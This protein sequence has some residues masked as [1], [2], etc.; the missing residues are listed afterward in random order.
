MFLDCLNHHAPLKKRVVLANEVPYMTKALRKAI[1]TRSRLENRYYRH[2][3]AESKWVYK[4]QK[5]YVSR[6]YKKERRKYYTNLDI[7]KI[8]DNK[9]FW[10]TMK[11]FFSDKGA[12]TKRNITLVEGNDILTE[13]KD[14]ANTLNS[15]FGDAVKSLDISIPNEYITVSSN[16]SDPIENIILKY[17][18]HPSIISINSNIIKS[19]FS[20]SVVNVDDIKTELDALNCKKSC[21]SDSIPAT[22]LKKYSSICSEPLYNIINDGFRNAA[23]DKD[24]KYADIIPVHKKDDTTEKSNYRPISLL[25]VV[26]KLFERFM[27]RQIGAFMDIYLSPY[28][29]GYRKGFNAQH[30]LLSLIEKWRISLDKKGSGGAVLM[31]LSKAFDTLNHDLLVAKAFDTLNHDLLVAKLHAYGFDRSALKLI[32][33]YLTNRWQRTK[34]NSSVSSWVELILGVPQGSVLG[35]LLFNLFI[36]DLFYVIKETDICNYADDNTLHTCDL[37]LDKLMEKLEGAAEN[38]LCWF[39]NN[40]MKMNSDK[41][42]LLIS[43]HKHE[44]L[45][46]NIGG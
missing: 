18:N 8:T 21:K 28:L 23:F 6:L 37:Q 40:G 14:V 45:I 4:K 38:A 3:T 24:L 11:P 43:G 1:A 17:A 32:K 2:K 19:T 20:F 22:F 16:I 46:A 27:Q 29:C 39:R 9:R 33:S 25:P 36:N 34:V 42:H 26:A 41:C 15:F 7:K 13:D 31:D 35:P 12:E 44:V 30:A 10:S 5:N